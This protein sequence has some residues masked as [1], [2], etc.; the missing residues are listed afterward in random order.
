MN[1]DSALEIVLLHEGEYSFDA[2][3]PGGETKYGISKRAFPDE[4][5]QNITKARARELYRH[6]YW[7]VCECDDLPSWAR[8]IVFDCAVNQG[9]AR[10]I[11][12]LQRVVGVQPDGII[13]L[14]TLNALQNT[15]PHE[16]IGLYAKQRLQ[17]YASNPR[18]NN[19]G[20]GW[21]ARLMDITVLSMAKLV[22]D[23]LLVS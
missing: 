19:Y 4:D 18:W 2:N 5:I 6:H 9:P 3:D 15:K 20:K 23:Q 8:L 14:K 10:A 21:Y 22:S 13:G 17:A 12:F 7:D 11:I 1:F 16:F